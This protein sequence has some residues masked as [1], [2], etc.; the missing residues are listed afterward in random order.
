MRLRLPFAP[1]G[2]GWRDHLDWWPRASR[3]TGTR[4]AAFARLSTKHRAT[5]AAADARH[6]RHRLGQDRGVPLPDPRPR[7]ARQA[8]RR[9]RDQGA[10]PLPDERAGQRPGRAARRADHRRPARWPR[11]PPASTPAS[12]ASGGRTRV[13]RRRA[14]HRPRA[15]CATRRRTSC[16][17]TTRCSTSCCCARGPRDSGGRP[18][19]QPAVPG[20]RRVPHLRRRAGHRRRDAAAPP[21]PHAEEPL[22]DTTRRHRRGPARPLGKITPVATSATLGDK[23]DPA[24]MLDFAHTVF[25]EPFDADAVITES[26]LDLDEWLRRRGSAVATM[27]GQPIEPAL[28]DA[29]ERDRRRRRA[30]GRRP[31]RRCAG[32]RRTLRDGR[33]E[34]S[35]RAGC[36][37]DR[38]RCSTCSSAHPLIQARRRSARRRGVARR[39]GRAGRFRRCSSTA[40]LPAPATR[41]SGSWSSSSR[42]SAHVR[43]A[44]GPRSA[45][46]RR[47]P[48]GPGAHPR[49]PRGRRRRRVPLGRR[50]GCRWPTTTPSC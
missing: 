47:A 49:R 11:S 18:P 17:P 45:R 34:P 21:R 15:S 24:A 37:D 6:H 9:H 41:G 25:G 33:Y 38:G 4:R 26:R 5:A 3:R 29:L 1:A 46:R 23:G 19:T 32:A 20:A 35:A 16:S 13:T 8:A 50:R 27:R 12:R 40:M 7:A 28:P 2:D 36:A 44:G 22:A 43:A 14:D 39:S 10:D 30:L 31:G 48:V 42:C